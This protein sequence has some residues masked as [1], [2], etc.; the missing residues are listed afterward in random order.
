MKQLWQRLRSGKDASDSGRSER[1]DLVDG[2]QLL[3]ST[4]L[5]PISNTDPSDIFIAGYPKSGN[6]WVQCLLASAIYGLD[7]SIA[8][9]LL[10]QDLVPDVH[11]R[12]YY[13]RYR[14][15][16]FFKTHALPQPEYRRVIYLLR[17]GRD[18]MV[19]YRHLLEALRKQPIDFLQ[20]VNSKNE[21][22]P[23]HW[24]EH[25]E[26][27][28]SNPHKAEMIVVRYEDMQKDAVGELKRMCEF[29]G[30]PREQ[31]VLELSVARSSFSVMQNR[32]KK[33]GWENKEW[34]KDKPFIR[35]GKVGSH[36][37]EMPAD[38]KAAYLARA[39]ATLKKMGYI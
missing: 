2:A 20:L 29:A 14:K 22:I 36:E 10:V 13:K 21:I 38:V 11:S 25:V 6:T 35:R 24:H 28:L 30:E 34:P 3:Q 12:L 9:D 23:T 5:V 8:P 16:C 7:S 1:S 31:S 18:V 17:D 15:S 26:Q 19:S 27:W 32:E 4:Q 39:G 37:D 33:L